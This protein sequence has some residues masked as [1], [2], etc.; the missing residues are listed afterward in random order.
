MFLIRAHKMSP[1]GEKLRVLDPRIGKF[2]SQNC[3][4]VVCIQLE[5]GVF[6]QFLEILLRIQS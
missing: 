3:E 6:N 5:L 4:T 1:L 2:G